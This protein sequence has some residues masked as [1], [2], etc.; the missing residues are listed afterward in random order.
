[1][2]AMNTFLIMTRKT[3]GDL[4]VT[5]SEI[6]PVKEENKMELR[7]ARMTTIRW[8]CGVKVNNKLFVRK[9]D[10]IITTL[11]FKRLQLCDPV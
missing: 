8:M 9:Y 4:H 1:M 3:D 5:S 7:D 11:Q 6:W 2:T 10:D